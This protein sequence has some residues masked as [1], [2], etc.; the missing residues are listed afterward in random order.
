MVETRSS[1]EEVR[2]TGFILNI[3]LLGSLGLSGLAACI[4]FKEWIR[5]DG[6]YGGT[7]PFV[8]LGVWAFFL[9]LYGMSRRG[10]VILSACIFIGIYLLET[11]STLYRWGADLPIGLLSYVLIIVLS[12]VLLGTAVT[13]AVTFALS[14]ILILLVRLQMTGAIESQHYWRTESVDMDD[15]VVIPAMFCMVAVVSWLFNREIKKSLRRALVSEAALKKERDLLEMRV[16][17]RTRELRQVQMEKMSQMYHFAEFGKLSS[18]LFHDL[19]NP[20]T[21]LS[22]HLERL[23]DAQPREISGMRLHLEEAVEATN[24]ME[25]FISAARK[26]IQKQETK[27][28][29]SPDKEIRQVIRILGYKAK[30][31]KVEVEFEGEGTIEAYGNLL[32]FSQVVANLLS[33]AIDAYGQ[34]GGRFARRKVV[35]RLEKR[36]SAMAVSVQDWGNGI[37]EEHLRRVFDPF[38]TTKDFERGTGI[39]LSISKEIVEKDFGGRIFVSSK[40]G[41]GTIFTVEIPLDGSL[42]E[43]R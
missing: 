5:L 1:D 17:E 3:L 39:G 4:A 37:S 18:G 11:T 35:L 33:N 29:F 7:S 34:D 14:A 31:G 28:L 42:S 12:G 26:Q 24:R 25:A 30:N 15:M 41:E 23:K 10:H 22:L 20:L 6:G 13:F 9:V 38:F 36:R 8:L 21:A 32:K 27:T 2:R 16:E 43:P 40:V 19:M